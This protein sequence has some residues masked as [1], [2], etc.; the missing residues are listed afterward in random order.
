M[1]LAPIALFA[2]NRPRH[3]ARVADALA[4]N[5]EA[6]R[7]RLVVYSD[8]AKSAASAEDVAAVR[9]VAKGVKSFLSVEVVEQTENKGIAQSIIDGVGDLVSRFGRV[10]VL[11]DDLLPSQHFLRFMNGALDLY[12][13]DERVASVHGY[14][15]PV[16]ERLPET[17]FL[18]GADCWGWATWKRAWAL[19]EPDGKRLLEEIEARVL[20]DRFD[21]DGSY[22][23]TEMLRDQIAGRNDSW[24]I[25]WHA[26]A[27]LEDRLTLYPASSQ[28]QNIGA[29]GS[30]SHVGHT[31]AFEHRD[32]GRPVDLQRIPVE[33]SAEAL[34]AFAR[35]LAGLRV[36]P[37]SRL[38]A[39]LSSLRTA[40]R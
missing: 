34:R 1:T 36:S 39:R 7:S 30:G 12:E 18:R 15:Y 4:R 6:D 35:F 22:P 8:A 26:S 2:Y 29:D 31:R 40:F 28:I 11:E 27:F 5:P 32:W 13:G 25:R 19:F 21:L 37:V 33:E 23:Y 9:A 20:A 17:F 38:L 3:L 10:I 16:P 14:S 24:A